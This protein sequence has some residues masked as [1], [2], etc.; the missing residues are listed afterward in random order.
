MDHMNLNTVVTAARHFLTQETALHGL[1]N[2]AGIMGTPFEMTKN[3]HEAQWQTNYL[4]H[5]ILTEHLL[6]TM[7]Q[8]SKTLPPGSIRIVNLSSSGHRSAPKDGIHFEDLSLKDTDPWKRYGQ[9]KLAN[10]LH[11]KTLHGKYGP[12]SPS[13]LTGTGEIWTM[14]VHPG[15]VSTNL[16]ASTEAS[17]VTKVISVVKM[18][19]LFY[20]AEKGAGTSLFGAASPEMKKEQSG[21]YF[22]VHGRWGEP[23]RLTGPAKDEKL[24]ERLDKWTRE[25]MRKEQ[26]IQLLF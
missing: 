3:G 5:W 2:N 26:W 19:G 24:G 16:T 1:I 25:T 8:T 13:A 15:L 7:L 18:L 14:S 11:T 17:S 22:E 20:S 12:N 10:I 9:S 21:T 6:P 4:A 23:T